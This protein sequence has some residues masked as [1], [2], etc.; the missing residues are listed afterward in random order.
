M[1]K[2]SSRRRFLYYFI[3]LFLGL[4][5]SIAAIGYFYWEKEA[6]LIRKGRQEAL[7]AIADLKAGQIEKWRAERMG[8]AGVLYDNRVFS[9]LV[10]QWLSAQASSGAGEEVRL[11]L[12]SLMIQYGY[13]SVFFIDAAGELR[14]SIPDE[15]RIGHPVREII[16]KA[17]GADRPFFLDL[18]RST[19]HDAPHMGLAI[20]VFSPSTDRSF[21]GIVILRIDP[22]RFLYPLVQSWPTPSKS[23]ETLLVRRE[24]DEV[25]FLNELRFRK[26]T[27][28][29]MR[30]PVNDSD[31]PAA[32]A[33]EG[34]E[35]PLEGVDYRGVPVLACVRPIPGSPWFLVA[36]VDMEEIYGPVRARARMTFFLVVLLVAAVGAVIGLVW[37]RQTGEFYRRQYEMEAEKLNLTM[38]Y[39]QLMKSA[40]DIILLFDNEGRVL[41]ANARATAAY[42]YTEE[43]LI[44]MEGSDLRSPEAQTSLAQMRAELHRSPGRIFETVHRRKDGSAFPVEVSATVVSMGGETAYLSIVRDI[45]E[46]KQAEARIRRLNRLYSCLSEINQAVVRVKDR[47]S[48]FRETCRIAVEHGQFGMAWI[49]VVD[50]EA[51]MFRVAEHYGCEEIQVDLLRFPLDS[52]LDSYGPMGCALQTGAIAVSN[53]IDHT[54]DGAPWHGMAMDLGF[55]SS[56]AVPLF[57]EGQPVAC[58]ECYSTEPDFFDPEEVRLLEEMGADMSFGLDTIRREAHREMV[59]AKLKESETAYRTIFENTG[60][61][62]IIIEEDE[63]ISL[64]NRKFGEISGYAPEEVMGIRKFAEFVDPRDRETAKE[65]HWLRRTQPNAAPSQYEL[66]VLDRAGNVR[67]VYATVAMIEG[68]LKSVASMVD[69]TRMKA[70]EAALKESEAKYRELVEN[71]SSIILRLDT[72]GRIVFFNRYAQQFFGYGEEEV[73]GRRLTDTVFSLP[74]GSES[75]APSAGGPSLQ[76][77][78]ELL[79]AESETLKR[80]GDRAWI[81]WTNK[82]VF[83]GDGKVSG[84]LCIGND[85]TQQKLLSEQYRQAQK[86]EAVGRLA[87]GIAHDFNNLLGVITGYSEVSLLGIEPCDQMRENIEHIK[88]AALRAANLT[89]Q[90]LAFSRKQILEPRVMSLNTVVE[91][92]ERMLRR[93]IGEDID[94][95]AHLAADLSPIK[96]DHGQI[97][98]V[99][100][101]L[102]VNAR[103]AMPEGG[104]LTIE[105]ANVELDE[106]YVREHLNVAPGRYVMLAVSDTGT[107]MDHETLSHIF[108]PFFTTKERDK[109]T[110]LGLSTV[111]GIVQQSNGYIYVYSEPGRGAAFK[112]YFPAIDSETPATVS[113]RDR[114]PNLK[115][116]ETVL[117]V[118]DETTMREII[119]EILSRFGYTVLCAANP[120]EALHT[121][122]NFGETIHLL[123]TDVVMPIMSGRVLSEVLQRSR[124]EIK[125]LFISGYTDN[126]IVHHGVLDDGLSFL[127]KPFTVDALAHRVREI[128]DEA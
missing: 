41:E 68:T 36:K 96:I 8:D 14:L 123:V 47:G 61:A 102:A 92:T 62:T 11:W 23:A 50:E 65:R 120:Q 15:S 100:M 3:A 124:P 27:A 55:K 127:Q 76:H 17:A 25:V 99:I 71:A 79:G 37:N 16:D 35:G 53:A 19:V 86:M 34:D 109:G 116:A 121:A 78:Q 10:L 106:N 31:L 94:F 59:E 40:N 54:L 104:K 30:L 48:L 126:A 24:G 29:A 72:E 83:D 45:S 63:T 85:V 7:S 13:E 18:H 80:N 101:N 91:E 26:N 82:A 21:L 117:V 33:V 42:G 115:G 98:Q 103:D 88:N 1:G 56:A 87:G 69:I 28:L 95:V 108:E 73:L 70:T 119:G 93:L 57:V 20:P 46:R 9:G 66:R 74:P 39:Q 110:G 58:F 6:N 51:G 43:E 89:R 75:V 122:A 118:E 112:L 5:F 38:R 4:A 114:L 107:G 105:T 90:L 32:R 2:N 44:G 128:L 113:R 97:E 60:T 52:G 125:I 111:Y 49:G 81:A 22:R 12:N 84:L 77:L 64:A 67:D